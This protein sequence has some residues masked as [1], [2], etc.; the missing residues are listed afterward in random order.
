MLALEYI[1]GSLSVR[2]VPTSGGGGSFFPRVF[3]DRGGIFPL[4]CF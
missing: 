3:Y 2:F 4:Y 1:R